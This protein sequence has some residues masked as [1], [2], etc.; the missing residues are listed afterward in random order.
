MMKQT[1]GK[2]PPSESNVP[3]TQPHTPDMSTDVD[4]SDEQVSGFES[5]RPEDLGIPF[6]TILQKGSPE[7]DETHQ[8]H[9]H[10][11]IEGA[12]AGMIIN[13]LTRE[14]VYSDRNKPL[15]FIPCHHVKLYQEWR[16]RNNSGG[17]VTSHPNATILTSCTRNERNEDVLPNGN[18]INTTS[19]FYGFYFHGGQWNKAII[20]LTSTQLKKARSWLNMMSSIRIAGKTPPMFSHVYNT[21]TAIE[22]N[23]KGSWYGWKFEISHALKASN[24]EIIDQARQVAVQM[25]NQKL[26]GAS[27][28]ATD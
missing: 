6:L 20:A 19:Y 25:S 11:K 9:G 3:A 24:S 17:F 22:N 12:K 2:T 5:T 27:T 10:K 7:V 8:D 16:P 15:E 21:I 1:K 28:E 23:D 26:L 18:I 14:L 4:W 13:T